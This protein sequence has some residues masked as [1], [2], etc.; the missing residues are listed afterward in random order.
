LKV[1]RALEEGTCSREGPGMQ[2][3]M[4][5]VARVTSLSALLGMRLEQPRC[6]VG[7]PGTSREGL[8]HGSGH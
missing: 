8:A 2:E 1:T 3:S 7:G 5:W 4:P 6:T